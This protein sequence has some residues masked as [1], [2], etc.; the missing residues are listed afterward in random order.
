MTYLAS[1]C[2]LICLL[3]QVSLLDVGCW[4][5]LLPRC[6]VQGLY[7]KLQSDP[8]KSSNDPGFCQQT[9]KSLV[10]VEKAMA[11]SMHHGFSIKRLKAEYAKK[12]VKMFCSLVPGFL[13]RSSTS[14]RIETECRRRSVHQPS[15]KESHLMS[16]EGSVS[17]NSS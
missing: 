5:Y 4:S 11:S 15:A 3:R 6:A 9:L 10:N 14:P 12:P 8:R 17:R 1:H 16:Y 13:R 7:L 2:R